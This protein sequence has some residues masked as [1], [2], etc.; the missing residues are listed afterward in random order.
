M[1]SAPTCVTL[2][3]CAPGLSNAESQLNALAAQVAVQSTVVPSRTV[4]VAPVWHDPT[5]A[6]VR[7]VVELAAAGVLITGSTVS[8]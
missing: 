8:V 2:M 1:V 7:S 3:V 4:M 5:I 6:G